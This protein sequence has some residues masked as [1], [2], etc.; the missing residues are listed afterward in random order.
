MLFLDNNNKEV[1]G[2]TDT[3][4]KGNDLK[5]GKDE[6]TLERTL[7]ANIPS[8]VTA[9]N[10]TLYVCMADK[11]NEAIINLPYDGVN[12]ANRKLYKVTEVGVR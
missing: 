2:I 4:T 3:S 6:L 5:Y 1:Y 9:G 10:L 12:S 7:T 11:N 8:T